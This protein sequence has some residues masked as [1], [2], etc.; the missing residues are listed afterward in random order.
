MQDSD[1]PPESVGSGHAFGID[2]SLDW[3][4][5]LTGWGHEV[6]AAATSQSSKCS[7]NG[8]P[9]QGI[10]DPH[11]RMI[12]PC[13]SSSYDVDQK[14]CAGRVARQVGSLPE[15]FRLSASAG[16]F[17]HAEFPQVGGDA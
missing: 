1:P 4:G 14:S 7:S 10:E 9:W 5:G 8:K 13:G 15:S 11:S 3:S 12:S 16:W 6:V 2:P 17:E